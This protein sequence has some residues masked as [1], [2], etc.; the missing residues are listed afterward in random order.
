MTQHDQNGGQDG[1]GPKQSEPRG[2]HYRGYL[3]HFEGGMI[4][5]AVTFRLGDSL[6][7]NVLEGW[8]SEL[9]H[10]PDEERKAELLTRVNVWL[11]AGHGE[12]LLRQ[13]PVA[14]LVRSALMHFNGTRYL[15]H[16]W[17]VMPNHVHALF[18]AKQGFAIAG[19]VHSWKSFTAKAINKLLGRTGSVWMP[20]YFD[21]FIR[22]EEHW[23]RAMAYIDSN[24]VKAGLCSRPEDWPWSAAG[25]RV[26]NKQDPSGGQDGRGP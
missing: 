8:M 14:E 19:I 18:T 5:Q 22:N 1:R 10:R 7:A 13:P 4:P 9:A 12:C 24:P 16:N 17:C 11:D 25:A 3:P 20:D 15:L 2:W 23:L 26:S 6:P 21:R